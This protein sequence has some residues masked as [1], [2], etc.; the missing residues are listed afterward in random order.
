MWIRIA[1]LMTLGTVSGVNAATQAPDI[2]G[3]Y[4]LQA[5]EIGSKLVL[6]PDNT[7]EAFIEYAGAEGSAKG[8]WKQVDNTLTLTSDAVEPPAENLLFNLGRTHSLAD[9]QDTQQPDGGDTF[10]QAQG[11][12]VLNLRYAR[13]RPV[14]SI[15]PVMVTFEFNQGPATQLL[16]NNAVGRQLYVPYTEQ[17]PLTRIGLQSS[18]DQPPQ[19]FAIAPQTR[20]LSLSWKVDRTTGQMSYDKPD[21]R[22]LAQSQQSFRNARKALAQIDH[23]YILTLLYGVT[24]QPPAIKP[25]DIYWSFDDG[26]Q[27]SLRWTDSRQA[28]LLLPAPAGKALNKIGVKSSGDQS[29]QWFD[30]ATHSRAIDLMWD[31]RVNPDQMRDL[32][33]VFK[34]L[35][36]EVQGDCL[37]VDLGNGLAC[38]RQ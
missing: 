4:T 22:D 21:E 34:T 30:V 19:W 17:R 16:W 33:E 31:E 36:L 8:H 32:S 25:V 27:Q 6:E 9:L 38:Y 23:N 1:L 28:Q 5:R 7:F 18:P 37:S 20:T 14:P 24:A 29:P 11:N 10:K 12:Y 26:S 35:E 13:S 3:H 15:A 2:A